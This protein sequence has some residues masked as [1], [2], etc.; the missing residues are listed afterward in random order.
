MVT[1]IIKNKTMETQY[2]LFYDGE[3]IDQLTEIEENN[4][5]ETLTSGKRPASIKWKGNTV[6]TRKLVIRKR[7]DQQQNR[8]ISDYTKEELHSILG[9]FEE[10]YN[11]AA[12]GKP[13]HNEIL[14][15]VKEGTVEHALK[16]GAITKKFEDIYNDY[17]YY[18]YYVHLPQYYDYQKKHNALRELI[19]RRDYAQD[20]NLDAIA[21]TRKELFPIS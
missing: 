12:T 1:S 10:E 11:K 17:V 8:I 14:G 2:L 20:K 19:L 18:V 9:N 6:E 5:S 7:G 16:F 3:E 15:W 13:I 4:L 21:E